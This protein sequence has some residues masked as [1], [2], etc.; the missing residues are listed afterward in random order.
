[1]DPQLLSLLS[2][3]FFSLSADLEDIQR[4]DYDWIAGKTLRLGVEYLRGKPKA[5]F[6][7]GWGVIAS[8]MARQPPKSR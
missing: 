7:G 6:W 8:H 5:L 4:P 3:T 2:A 1:M